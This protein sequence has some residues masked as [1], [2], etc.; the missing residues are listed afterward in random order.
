MLPRCL[1]TTI[2]YLTLLTASESDDDS[3]DDVPSKKQEDD[4]EDDSSHDNSGNNSESEPLIHRP[5][6]LHVRRNATWL[7][8]VIGCSRPSNLM[9]HFADGTET[10]VCCELCIGGK[11]HTEECEAL[12]VAVAETAAAYTTT[13]AG[14]GT[15]LN[16]R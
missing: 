2:A 13:A 1:T 8:S 9:A 11:G 12:L 10:L 6:T 14:R 5:P 3:D 15:S 4:R 7:C 16:M